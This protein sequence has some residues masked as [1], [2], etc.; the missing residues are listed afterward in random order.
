MYKNFSIFKNKQS[1]NPKSPTHSIS[2]KV[3]EEYVKVGSCWTKE[4]K[5]G[6]K[7]LSCSLQDA[8]VDDTD[9]SKSRKAYAITEDAT[10]TTYPDKFTSE[11]EQDISKNSPF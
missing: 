10:P 6:D 5:S 2:M 11:Q 8:Y 1:D 7:F 3:G 4:S 9:R